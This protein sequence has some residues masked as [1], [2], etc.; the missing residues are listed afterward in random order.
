MTASG[1]WGVVGEGSDTLWFVC[2]TRCS[3][4]V[5]ET[6]MTPKGKRAKIRNLEDPLTTEACRICIILGRSKYQK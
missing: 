4:E 6:R 5:S 1:F 2:A 3:L